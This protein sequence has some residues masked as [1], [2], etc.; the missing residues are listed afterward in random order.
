V[1]F[2]SS[3]RR[4]TRFSRDWSSDVCSSDLTKSS[5]AWF[6]FLA[7]RPGRRPV[8][9]VARTVVT[10]LAAVFLAAVFFTAVF[11]AAVFFT[12]AFLAAVFLAAVLLAVPP[13]STSSP[14]L[15]ESESTSRVAATV[16]VLIVTSS[17][18]SGE[19]RVTF[20]IVAFRR[21]NIT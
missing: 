20:V 2:F 5:A 4:H 10:F 9:L 8:D 19:T 18:T 7:G 13:P 21:R 1:F 6:A 14:T 17:V 16:L 15:T 12:A 11:L 3:R